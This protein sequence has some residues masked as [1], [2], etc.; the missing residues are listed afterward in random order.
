MRPYRPTPNIGYQSLLR[1]MG[2]KLAFEW[3]RRERAMN[4]SVVDEPGEWDGAAF[5]PAELA[6]AFAWAVYAPGLLGWTV[7]ADLA[8]DGTDSFLV[9]PPLVYGGGFEIRREG[10]DTVISW[11][12]GERRVTSLRDA[13]LLIC[14]LSPEALTAVEALAA[15]PPEPT[16]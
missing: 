16:F 13:M 10:R 5:S 9:D 3:R 11:S 14:P 2:K 1:M 7:R 15:A 12:V 4:L 8:E 6:F